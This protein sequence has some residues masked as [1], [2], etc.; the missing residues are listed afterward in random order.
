MQ[1]CVWIGSMDLYF[2]LSELE[3]VQ[4]RS[5]SKSFSWMS[6][7]SQLWYDN[8]ASK[9][10]YNVIWTKVKIGKQSR[11]LLKSMKSLRTFKKNLNSLKN[12]DSWKKSFSLA[13]SL[14]PRYTSIFIICIQELS[15]LHTNDGIDLSIKSS[16]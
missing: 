13:L 11:G 9:I 10:S 6:W 3:K 16:F 2:I 1:F 4:R 15:F 12:F 14:S 8:I 7:M 5:L